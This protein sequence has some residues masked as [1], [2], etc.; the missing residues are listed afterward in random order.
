VKSGATAVIASGDKLLGGPQAGLLLGEA[1]FI[2]RARAHPL[3]RAMRAD[4]LT[5]A[6]LAATLAL[7]RDEAVARREIPVLRMLGA[8]AD[9]LRARAER[10]AAA[11]P[12]RA[13]PAVVATRAAVGGGSFPGVEIDS[14]GVSITLPDRSAAEVAAALRNRAV[15][16]VAVVTKGRVV[17][18]VRTLLPGDDDLIVRAVAGLLA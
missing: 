5:L 11:L 13:A 17:L 18:D 3:A 10:L 8:R 7:Y 14:L 16:I 2:K 9:E 15:P 12:P 4:K 1:G 6:G